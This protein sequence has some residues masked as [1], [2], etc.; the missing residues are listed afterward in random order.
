MESY[1]SKLLDLSKKKTVYHQEKCHVCGKG[2][3][4]SWIS[5]KN[6]GI[7][8]NTDSNISPD[9]LHYCSYLCFTGCTLDRP[10]DIWPLIQNQEDFNEPRPVK[11]PKE[12]KFQYLT[13]HEISELTDQERH[14][15]YRLKDEY[16]MM[17]PSLGNLYDELYNEDLKTF[18]I[19]EEFNAYE[20]D[21]EYYHSD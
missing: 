12:K 17:N 15:Y 21:D 16:M 7:V 18:A 19:E 5:I 4:K 3:T 11:K 20:S 10:R 1:Q 13:Y 6:D 9:I 2:S 8:K 14:E